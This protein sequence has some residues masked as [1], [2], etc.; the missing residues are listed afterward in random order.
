MLFAAMDC[1]SGLQL[2]FA[3]AAIALSSGH[4]T[5]VAV[6]D[7][8][9]LLPAIVLV[10]VCIPLQL[11]AFTL[12]S[13]MSCLAYGKIGDESNTLPICNNPGEEERDS[14]YHPRP[15]VSEE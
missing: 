6:A 9:D 2:A 8:G 11:V 13:R 14:Q 12:V 5:Y 1:H 15:A 7:D 10:S 3:I 4:H